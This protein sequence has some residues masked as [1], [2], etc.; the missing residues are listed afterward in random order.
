VKYHLQ[1]LT[2][3]GRLKRVGSARRGVWVIG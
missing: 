2:K 3:S 1:K